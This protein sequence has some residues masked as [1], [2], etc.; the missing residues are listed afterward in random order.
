LAY[1]IPVITNETVLHKQFNTAIPMMTAELANGFEDGRLAYQWAIGVH[2]W[3]RHRQQP[4]F[5]RIDYLNPS[6]D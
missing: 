2:A 3:K 4:C 6:L 1:R 5:I